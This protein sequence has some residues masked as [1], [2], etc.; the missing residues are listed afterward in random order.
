MAR[1]RLPSCVEGVSTTPKKGKAP[2]RQRYEAE[3]PSLT[4]RVP[5]EVKARIA[6]A[7]K[8]EGL[9][10]SEWVQAMAAG[11]AADATAAYRRGLDAGREQGE[12]AQ[13]VL[14]A[15]NE[16]LDGDTAGISFLEEQAAA[17]I[18]GADA[19]TITYLRELA[20]DLSLADEVDD[21][22]RA[23]ERASRAPSRKR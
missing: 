23:H 2:S 6:E 17:E 14:D 11:H 21:W 7:A 3:H 8:A 15:L 13:A 20:T 19:E 12:T 9:S 18:E 10:V 5:A 22:L 1:P 16:G 4:V